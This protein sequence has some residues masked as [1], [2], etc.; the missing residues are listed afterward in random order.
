MNNEAILEGLLF[1]AGD[2]GVTL[3]Q[4]C[5]VLDIDINSA[6][7]L[8]N[9]LIKYYENNNRGIFIKL[10][11]DK[12]IFTTKPEYIKYYNLFKNTKESNILSQSSLET[13]AIIAYNEPIT[14]VEVDELRGVNSGYIIRK[15]ITKNLICECGKSKLP[16]KPMLYK[17]TDYFLKYFGISNLSELPKIDDIK[18]NTEE[19]D[20]YSS[21]ETRQN[22][23]LEIID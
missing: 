17:T 5:E 20:L 11:G 7:T 21:T 9:N 2:D 3:K 22:D 16:G 6:K 12:Y 13:L 1:V 23:N 18:V 15:L 8:V 14:R 4:I 10:Y 19:I